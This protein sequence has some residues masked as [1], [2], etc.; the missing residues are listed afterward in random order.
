MLLEVRHCP[1]MNPS[2]KERYIPHSRIIHVKTINY[3]GTLLGL[4]IKF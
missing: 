4:E 1:A 3:Y 2:I